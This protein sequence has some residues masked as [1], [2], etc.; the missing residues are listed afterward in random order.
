[1]IEWVL[2]SHYQDSFHCHAQSER[3]MIVRGLAEATLTPLMLEIERVYPKFKV[4]S[5]PILNL[6]H[7][8]D[9]EIELGVKGPMTDLDNAFT[10]LREGAIALGGRVEPLVCG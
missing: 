6:K 7:P 10:R 1:M 3:S 9:Y 8:D 2:D 4:F 5:L